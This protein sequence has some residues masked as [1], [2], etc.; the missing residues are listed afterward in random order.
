M[1]KMK[2]HYPV[3]LLVGS[4]LFAGCM[5]G[6]NFEKP[7]PEMPA[8][9]VPPTSQPTTQQSVA[10][11]VPTDVAQWWH[12]FDDPALTSLIERALESNLDLKEATSRIREARAARGVTSS[13]LWPT[14]DSSGSYRRSGRGDG[15]T[16]HNDLY[17]AGLDA[18]WEIDIFGG[19]RRS[20][21]ASDAQIEATIEDRRDVMITLTSEVALNYLDLRGFQRAIVI[22]K[23]NLDAQ[24]HSADLTRQLKGGGFVGGLDLANAEAQVASTQSAIPLLEASQ[25]QAIYRLS[26]LL[27][28]QPA[29]L[30]AELSEPGSI[31]TVPPEIP[32]GL[33]SELLRR[34]PD[35]RRAEA[36]VHAATANIGVATSDLFPRFSLTGAFS[37]AGDRPQS[38]LNLDNSVWSLGPSVSWPIFQGGRIHSNIE[39]QNARQEQTLIAYQRT[40]LVA[41]QDVEIALVAYEK[42][43]QHH[44]SLVAAVAANRR[45]VD[46]STQ[47]YRQG[48]TDFLNVL[49]AQRS[50]LA[51][52]SAL[53]DSDRTIAA[54]LVALYKALGGGWES[55]TSASN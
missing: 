55:E 21:E 54:N 50:L 13:A 26:V 25:Q 19:N 38:L 51:T 14:L 6:P 11:S 8:G 28:M 15:N 46:L 36:Q 3:L 44:D 22:A 31:P 12:N 10:V 17:R 40:I 20:V 35:I 34:R 41:L 29:A 1:N 30:L 53:V 2:S 39:V 45:A 49:S 4:T 23:Q 16:V 9:W 33:P 52:E 48:Q 24:L 18:A 5:V 47:L 7:N 43:Q 42:E 32:V 27:G 37:L